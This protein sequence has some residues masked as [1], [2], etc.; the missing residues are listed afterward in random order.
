MMSHEIG[1][2]ETFNSDSNVATF[3]NRENELMM[4]KL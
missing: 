3:L 2:V 1:N 4:M